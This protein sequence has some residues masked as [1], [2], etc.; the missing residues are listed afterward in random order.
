M[1]EKVQIVK[2]KDQQVESLNDRITSLLKE[3]ERLMRDYANDIRLRESEMESMRITFD[4][5][6]ARKDRER[7]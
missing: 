5:D 1:A 6:L 2:N 4:E 7:S 3:K